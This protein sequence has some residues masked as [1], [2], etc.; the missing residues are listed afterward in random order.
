MREMT[1]S[2]TARWVDARWAP[3][4]GTGKTLASSLP[5]RRAWGQ[6]TVGEPPRAGRACGW[7]D[8]DATERADASGAVRAGER[9]RD[10]PAWGTGRGVRQDPAVGAASSSV[11]PVCRVPWAWGPAV[12]YA[13]RS[14]PRPRPEVRRCGADARVEGPVR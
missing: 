7:H 10:R 5:E 11:V 12:Q 4:A 1:V 8:A 2:R 3:F 9:A 14:V 6:A 13:S